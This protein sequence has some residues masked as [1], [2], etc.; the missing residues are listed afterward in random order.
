[1]AVG[2]LLAGLLALVSLVFVIVS[3]QAGPVVWILFAAV[4]VSLLALGWPSSTCRAP[5]RS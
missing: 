5:R 3:G 4:T 1:M 2:H